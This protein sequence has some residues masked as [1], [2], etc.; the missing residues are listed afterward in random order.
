MKFRVLSLLFVGVAALASAEPQTVAGKPSGP[1]VVVVA[2]KPGAVRLVHADQLVHEESAAADYT[3]AVVLAGPADRVEWD[4]KP[5]VVL[6]GGADPAAV[7]RQALEG[8]SAP[9]LFVVKADGTLDVVKALPDDYDA[10]TGAS[11][12]E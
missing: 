10:G 9:L 5:A 4:G 8:R 7:A 1:V 3:A 2:G 11:A 12:E 6:A